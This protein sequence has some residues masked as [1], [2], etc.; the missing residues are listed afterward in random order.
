M[1]LGPPG[2]FPCRPQGATN[3]VARFWGRLCR[4]QTSRVF[5]TKKPI[6][7][8]S[9]SRKRAAMRDFAEPPETLQR[10]W[11]ADVRLNRLA[12]VSQYCNIAFQLQLYCVHNQVTEMQ[13]GPITNT[14]KTRAAAAARATGLAHLAAHGN[15]RNWCHIVWYV[16]YP[17]M[18]SKH[19]MTHNNSFDLF[20]KYRGSLV[21]SWK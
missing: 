19:F 13:W 11:T 1:Q 21:N 16:V 4:S 20:L 7:V 2:P 6:D 14:I 15:K 3:R 18:F 9:W 10:C 8:S 17:R 5:S 12:C